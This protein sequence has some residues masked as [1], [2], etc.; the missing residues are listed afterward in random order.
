MLLLEH[1]KLFLLKSLVNHVVLSCLAVGTTAKQ[2]KASV[3]VGDL[4]VTDGVDDVDYMTVPVVDA[5]IKFC[6]IF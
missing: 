5:V 1:L 2:D 4:D 3:G 6:L